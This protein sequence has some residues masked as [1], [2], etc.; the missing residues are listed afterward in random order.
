MNVTNRQA[1]EEKTPQILANLASCAVRLHKQIPA[2][3]A[4]QSES[5]KYP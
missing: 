3:T 1:H 5:H 4:T 2:H